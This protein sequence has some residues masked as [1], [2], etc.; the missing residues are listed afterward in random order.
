M[1]N[2][3]KIKSISCGRYILQTLLTI[4]PLL[5]LAGFITGKVL[6]LSRD[7][8]ITCIIA[9]FI[10][11][12][13]LGTLSSFKNYRKF[14]KPLNLL[15]ELAVNLKNNNLSYVIDLSKA[16]GQKN[17]IAGV[18]EAINNL[19]NIIKEMEQLGVVVSDSSKKMT[20]VS[21]ELSQGTEQIATTVSELANGA[22]QQAINTE[23]ANNKIREI[24]Q[25]IEQILETM[26][27]AKAL[28]EQANDTLITG[29][30]SVKNQETKMVQRKEVV[31]N[32][33]EAI[34]SLE[35]KSYEIINI[36]ESVEEI[37]N[38]INLLSLNAAIEAARAGEQGRG[39]A[40]VAEE[41]K[42]LAEQSS[43]SVKGIG[44]IIKEVQV[45]IELSATQMN[46]AGS[47]IDEQ[48]KALADTVRSFN[49]ISQA[50]KTVSNHINT[51]TVAT[52][53]V[54]QNA[55]ATGH[56]I[57]DI[58]G[59]SQQ[60]ASGTQEIAASAEEQTSSMHHITDASG[61]LERLSNQLEESLKRFNV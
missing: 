43:E 61:E 28:S 30:E 42:K 32:V 34:S 14:V 27:N 5:C 10:A 54:S 12:L 56:L 37:S 9:F 16:G 13:I 29:G 47:V 39:F 51:V 24:I 31:V 4:I 21:E 46:N 57:G 33:I 44:D 1:A 3:E 25:G 15:G 6:G 8:I 35:E 7:K 49:E 59:I 19:R 50:V 45:N 22:S 17:I 18:N 60:I 20:S 11:G 41:V 2:S 36:M 55:K 48:E 52:N 38:Q 53:S 40:V 26:N 23:E 58:A